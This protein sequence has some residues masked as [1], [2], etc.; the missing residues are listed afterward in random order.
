MNT[1]TTAAKPISVI[2]GWLS[3]WWGVP[4]NEH[5]LR[6]GDRF[7]GIGF[8]M[9]LIGVVHAGRETTSRSHSLGDLRTAATQALAAGQSAVEV[10]AEALLALCGSEAW[11]H[12][13][14]VTRTP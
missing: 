9:R 6:P 3:V 12:D 13:Q 14:L 1:Q 5:V 8:R 4:G 10:D 11:A 2:P 7:W